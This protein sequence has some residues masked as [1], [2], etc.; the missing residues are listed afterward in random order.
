MPKAILLII[1]FVISLNLLS[2]NKKEQIQILNGRIDS[3]KISIKNEQIIKQHELEDLEKK[4]KDLETYRNELEKK[5]EGLNYRNTEYYKSIT[6][7]RDSLI[8]FL[9]EKNNFEIRY[10]SSMQRI[11]ELNT[12]LKSKSDSINMFAREII[13]N[14]AKDSVKYTVLYYKQEGCKDCISSGNTEKDTSDIV[15][16]FAIYYNGQFVDPPTCGPIISNQIEEIKKCNFSKKELVPLVQTGKKLFTILN[17]KQTQETTCIKYVE[18]GFSDWTR[19]SSI[20]QKKLKCDMLTNNPYIGLIYFKDPKLPLN[21][22]AEPNPYGGFLYNDLISK[23]DIDMDG[24]AEY[25]YKCEADEGYY[26][27][28]YSFKNNKWQLVYNGGYQGV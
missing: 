8:S 5:I 6:I 4:I 3:L 22:K 14:R 10:R 20:I 1:L 21:I 16:P 23:L 19:P 27:R 25:I 9:A 28:I 11:T 17:G 12:L 24:Y 7:I 18:H 13:I 26:F 15:I 2:Q